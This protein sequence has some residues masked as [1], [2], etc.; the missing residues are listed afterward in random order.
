MYSSKLCYDRRWKFRTLV[1]GVLKLLEEMHGKGCQSN[2]RT[3][4]TLLMGLCKNKKL[5]K[6]VEVYKSMAAA[7][8]KLKSLVY[9][10]FVRA[11]CRSGSI[12]DAY[13]VFDYAIQT[14]SRG[15]VLMP[16]KFN[17]CY[18]LFVIDHGCKDSSK[19]LCD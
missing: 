5:D 1:L 16:W 19:K 14:K 9:A 6:A 3:Y 12:A 7:G 17:K 11:L 10:S 15:R 13:E 4:S 8:T 18:A 2:E